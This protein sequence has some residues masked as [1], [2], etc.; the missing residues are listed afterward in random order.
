MR[1]KRMDSRF[2]GND[3][4][5]KK[6]KHGRDAHATPIREIRFYSRYS[7]SAVFAFTDN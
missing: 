6:K 1:M 2:R 3:R 7:C 4:K 5:K